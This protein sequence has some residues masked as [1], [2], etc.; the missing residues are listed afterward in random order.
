MTDKTLPTG[1]GIK[2]F[3]HEGPWYGRGYCGICGD[4]GRGG[5]PGWLIPSPVRW[6]DPDDGWTFGVLCHGCAREA[7]E[8]GPR[9]DDY[10]SHKEARDCAMRIDLGVA[11]G[12]ADGALID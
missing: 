1:P 3:M 7:A 8:R 4:S 10:A 6:W 9:P 11:L 12:D 5:A 2:W